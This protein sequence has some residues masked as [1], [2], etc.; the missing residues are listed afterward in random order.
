M[1]QDAVQDGARYVY[2]A[3]CIVGLV[4]IYT[5]RGGAICTPCCAYIP[6]VVELYVHRAEYL[7]TANGLLM[8]DFQLV[9]S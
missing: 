2:L 6:T 4:D 3:P 5:H 9:N 7:C 1:V 8:I